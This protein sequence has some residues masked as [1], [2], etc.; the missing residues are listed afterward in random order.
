[1]NVAAGPDLAAAVTNAGGLGVIG[2]VGY[3]PKVLRMQVGRMNF[4][5]CVELMAGTDPRTQEWARDILSKREISAPEFR[6]IYEQIKSG[7][8][9]DGD[10]G[11]RIYDK[12]LQQVNEKA[13]K[14]K[15]EIQPELA[16][17]ELAF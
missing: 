10:A 15:K 7:S 16:L 6:D 11:I 2:G 14:A 17:P 8:I 12:G 13:D 3:T 9:P 4:W 1:M 5:A